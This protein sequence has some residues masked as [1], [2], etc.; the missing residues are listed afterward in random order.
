MYKIDSKTYIHVLH[1][2]RVLLG[3]P[4]LMVFYFMPSPYIFFDHKTLVLSQQSIINSPPL[5][6]IPPPPSP[7]SSSPNLHQHLQASIFTQPDF[8]KDQVIFFLALG[9]FKTVLFYC[10]LTSKSRNKRTVG[11]SNTWVGL[12][13]LSVII[14][15]NRPSISM[16]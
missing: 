6:L 8:T 14:W 1:E 16:S 2:N 11:H 15:D 13:P 4:C 9:R 3:C 10:L 7:Y 12:V 5:S